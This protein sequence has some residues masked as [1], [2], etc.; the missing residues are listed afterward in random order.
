MPVTQSLEIVLE[1]IG[2]YIIN[3][4]LLM[5]LKKQGVTHDDQ[6]RAIRQTHHDKNHSTSGYDQ[7]V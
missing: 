3:T 6:I 4:H 2:Q 5:L 7:S 1:I